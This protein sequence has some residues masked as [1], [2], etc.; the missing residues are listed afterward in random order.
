[1]ITD[2][3]ATPRRRQLCQHRHCDVA[4]TESL[5]RNSWQT[6]GAVP[7]TS[8]CT[9]AG[10]DCPGLW[11][12]WPCIPGTARGGGPASPCCFLAAWRGAQRRPAS[13]HPGPEHVLGQ[14]ASRSSTRTKG[15]SPSACSS[16]PPGA[17]SGTPAPPVAQTR[18]GTVPINQ[19]A[20]GCVSHLGPQVRAHNHTRGPHPS[21]SRA[22]QCWEHICRQGLFSHFLAVPARQGPE[23]AKCSSPLACDPGQAVPPH[24]P[25]EQGWRQEEPIT[26]GGCRPAGLGAPVAAVARHAQDAGGNSL[27]TSVGGGPAG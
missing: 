13:G 22:A 1:M 16:A 26:Q 2:C 15:Q 9:R 8:L 3:S 24:L 10:G 18:A 20:R 21:L 12:P 4:A 6:P 23:R 14:A 5:E 27:S 11:G 19:P 7:G 25:R 17:P